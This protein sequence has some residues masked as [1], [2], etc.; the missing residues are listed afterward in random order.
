MIRMRLH[1][2]SKHTLCSRP[3][4]RQIHCAPAKATIVSFNHLFWARVVTA[5]IN[6]LSGWKFFQTFW[7]LGIS[8]DGIRHGGSVRV[9]IGTRRHRP[10]QFSRPRPTCAVDLQVDS[11]TSRQKTGIWSI[12]GRRP[13]D[14]LIWLTVLGSCSTT[15]SFKSVL[16]KD[17]I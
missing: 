17:A 4:L 5:R 1:A 16:H 6:K 2:N 10:T 3:S 9:T 15:K 8:S 13:D 12:T 7:R 14:H 11:G